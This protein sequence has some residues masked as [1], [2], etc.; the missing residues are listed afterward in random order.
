MHGSGPGR[1]EDDLLNPARRMRWRVPELTLLLG[2][3]LTAQA[4]LAGDRSLRL[5][6]ETLAVFASNRLGRSIAVTERAIA[7]T[8]DAAEGRAGVPHESLPELRIELACCA[9]VAGSAHTALRVLEPVLAQDRIEPSIR[10]HALVEMSAALPPDSRST[11]RAEACAEAERLYS[12]APELDED[13]AMLLR[14][15]VSAVRAGHTRREGAASEAVTAAEAGLELL[16]AMPDPEADSGE[17][18]SLL[19]LER[20]HGLL[21]L[22]R[23]EAALAAA[24]EV[25]NRPV[26]A[27]S[28]KSV[29]W[30][31]LAIATRVHL[32]AGDH[33]AA[34][35][36][37][38]ESSTDAE[39]HHCG[40]VHAE[41]L[42]VLS[43]V[44]ERTAEYET[45]LRCLRDA[46]GIE[47]RW[48]T[49][50]HT[51]R[52]RVLEE[53]PRI[54]APTVVPQ[55]DRREPVA[56][57][58]APPGES[59]PAF[60]PQRSLPEQE[61][62]RDAA[63]RLME[64]LSGTAASSE[65]AADLIGDP[66][67]EVPAGPDW[68]V[69][70]E[71]RMFGGPEPVLVDDLSTAVEDTPGHGVGET[72]DGRS[73]D[74]QVRSAGD[75]P[76]AFSSFAE[77]IL[78]TLAEESAGER[79]ESEPAPSGGASLDRARPEQSEREPERNV[80]S[81]RA[82]GVLASMFGFPVDAGAAVPSFTGSR[83]VAEPDVE[84]DEEPVPD[85]RR[86]GFEPERELDGPAE[87][88]EV[89]AIMPVIATPPAD[90]AVPDSAPA[91]EN[92]GGESEPT[93]VEDPAPLGTGSFE[94]FPSA[95]ST[96]GTGAFPAA[97]AEPGPDDQ[98]GEG[99]RSRGKSLAEIRAG[100]RGAP[101]AP[102]PGTGGRRRRAEPDEE[103]T[104]R[105]A[106]LPEPTGHEPIG[107]APTELEVLGT[108]STGSEPTLHEPPEPEPS[109]DS[110][111]ASA[112]GDAPAERALRA[113]GSAKH[114]RAGLADLLTEALMA[115]ETGRRG[116]PVAEERPT[117]TDSG[118]RTGGDVS[119][120][121]L[122]SETGTVSVR[123]GPRRS[124]DREEGRDTRARHRHGGSDQHTWTPR[125][126]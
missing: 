13:T 44:Y 7:A 88:A 42:S 74:E 22:G 124:A 60:S 93:R 18:R 52:V 12:A 101:E 76:T 9:R 104:A 85:E 28:A 95:A 41:S 86:A 54:P 108:G 69:T 36:L 27:A 105:E 94:A 34:L 6:A 90:P 40:E 32:P 113:V 11:E 65:V 79:A 10:A 126:R 66:H 102:V 75:E 106:V 118:G 92:P 33:D 84:P 19:V 26:R 123:G 16:A 81:G 116:E 50:A 125:V 58:E 82:P 107:D 5:R 77:H 73:E 122:G 112:E 21:D 71:D 59:A 57:P 15:R 83:R 96:D 97:L 68:A 61:S 37:L 98:A 120:I 31:R 4:R 17:V 46:Y 67:D 1:A 56:E 20:V 100:L 119:G 103:P 23:H 87:R 3:R 47:R 111:A 53:F 39:R 43:Q 45:A 121:T 63:R 70:V 64:T 115:Y 91:S 49:A 35:R 109:G 55:Q 30:L 24:D 8:H 89:T 110:V 72:S 25:L 29:G 2:D 48:R 99:R 78:A 38:A 62:A 14:A 80:L 51:A 117:G 114:S